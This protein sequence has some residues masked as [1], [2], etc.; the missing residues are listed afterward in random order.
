MQAF[1]AQGIEQRF[2][3]PC[4]GGSN[5]SRRVFQPLS[6]VVEI[7]VLCRILI[8]N[9]DHR[10]RKVRMENGQTNDEKRPFPGMGFG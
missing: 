8:C 4:V 10:Q 7:G 9:S 5:P 1:V 2:P 6:P 3:V